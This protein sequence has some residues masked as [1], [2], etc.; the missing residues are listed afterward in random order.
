M[1]ESNGIKTAISHAA[2]AIEK[3]RAILIAAGAGMGVDS[4]LPDFRGTEG[5]WRVYPALGRAGMHFGDIANP[6]AFVDQPQL[7]WGFY[8]HRLA[9]YPKIIPHEGFFN[10]RQ[11]QR[12]REM[13]VMVVT[14]RYDNP[15][16]LIARWPVITQKFTLTGCCGLS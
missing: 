16:F 12:R 4:G 9:L 7:A 5:F 11:L 13:S 8:G 2:E 6:Q 14:K 10:D 15:A 3:A 1:N